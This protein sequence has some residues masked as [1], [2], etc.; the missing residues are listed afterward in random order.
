[1]ET[2]FLPQTVSLNV[3]WWLC[4][5]LRDREG[6]RV[7]ERQNLLVPGLFQDASGPLF[8]DSQPVV[9]ISEKSRGVLILLHRLIPLLKSRRRL[10][11]RRSSESRWDQSQTA[12][13]YSRKGIFLD[14]FS[15]FFFLYFSICWLSCLGFPHTTHF[16]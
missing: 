13:L 5:P 16:F 12:N 6:C 10:L 8:D 14:N 4:K 9:I 2:I 3:R 11:P 1:M 7:S 15:F